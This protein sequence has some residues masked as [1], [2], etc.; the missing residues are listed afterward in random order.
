MLEESGLHDTP[1]IDSAY[2]P[3]GNEAAGEN[4]HPSIIAL[5]GRG[6]GVLG[7][8]KDVVAVC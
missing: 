8:M 2:N 4:Y 1:A 5:R 3:E 7:G 6:V